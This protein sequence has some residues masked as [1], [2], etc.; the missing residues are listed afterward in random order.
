MNHL[1]V[2]VH[3]LREGKKNMKPKSKNSDG[4]NLQ[5]ALRHERRKVWGK[6]LNSPEE[7]RGMFLKLGM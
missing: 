6:T 4:S 5:N 2:E 1:K 7:E 3:N